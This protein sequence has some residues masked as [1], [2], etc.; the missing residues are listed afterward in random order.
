[1]KPVAKQSRLRNSRDTAAD[2][3]GKSERWLWEQSEPR[4]PIPCIRLGK[5]VLYDWDLIEQWL[6]AHRKSA[7]DITVARDI[8]ALV[9]AGDSTADVARKLHFPE[10]TVQYVVDHGAFPEPEPQWSEENETGDHTE[11][12]QR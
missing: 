1:M 3:F 6:A 4:G 5:S 10:R 7:G 12:G 8:L 2:F 11:G 9:E